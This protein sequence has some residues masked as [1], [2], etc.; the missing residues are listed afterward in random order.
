VK[1]DVQLLLQRALQSLEGSLL[2][3]PVD[4]KLVTLERAR[5]A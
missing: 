2:N 1:E 5:D 3:G 4:P